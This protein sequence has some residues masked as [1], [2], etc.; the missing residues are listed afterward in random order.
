MAQ[1]DHV[2]ADAAMRNGAHDR[3][4]QRD[5]HGGHRGRPEDVGLVGVAGAVEHQPTGDRQEGDGGEDL[6]APLE[7]LAR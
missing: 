5:Q 1:G 7:P 3:D 4:G 2:D 6:K